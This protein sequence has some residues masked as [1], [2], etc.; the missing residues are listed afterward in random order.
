MSL[1]SLSYEQTDWNK[2][3]LDND[4]NSSDDTRIT[5]LEGK[6]MFDQINVKDY[7]AVGDGVTDDTEAIQAVIDLYGKAY[8]YTGGLI[9][10]PSGGYVLTDTI[11]LV[12]QGQIIQGEGIGVGSATSKGTTFIWRGSND[13]PMFKYVNCGHTAM[14]DLRIEGRDSSPPTAAIQM[15]GD[16][17]E[18]GAGNNSRQELSNVYIGAYAWAW[19]G[20]SDGAVQAGI[21]VDGDDGNNDMKRFRNI[22]IQGTTGVTNYGIKFENPQSVWSNIENTYINNCAVGFYTAATIQASNLAFIS[23]DVDI[24]QASTSHLTIHGYGSESSG[25]LL[26]WL[27]GSSKVTSIVGGYAQLSHINTTDN[28]ALDCTLGGNSR[29]SVTFEGFKFSTNTGSPKGKFHFAG[30]TASSYADN[31]LSLHLLECITPD[32][33]SELTIDNFDINPSSS[34]QKHFIEIM[35][36]PDGKHIKMLLENGDVFAMDGLHAS[37]PTASELRRGESITIPGG[38]G[39]R[40]QT[41]VCE[42]NASDNYVWVAST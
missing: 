16:N 32:G 7:G 2:E 41:W 6:A 14:R 10:F 22:R 17:T 37:L 23:C 19:N 9:Y 36:T 4:Q 27:D 1:N 30:S 8:G 12:R 20:L 5:A 24:Q 29:G 31:V 18:T 42:K 15:S 28:Y 33:L 25:K 21:L 13:R 34:G 35:H 39:V 26:E 38:A 11:N 40:D 3:V